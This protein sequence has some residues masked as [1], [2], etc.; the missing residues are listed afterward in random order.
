MEMSKQSAKYDSQEWSK[1]RG[2]GE[3]HLI[4]TAVHVNS[5]PNTYPKSAGTPR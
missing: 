5:A 4:V 3:Y 2:F 1:E